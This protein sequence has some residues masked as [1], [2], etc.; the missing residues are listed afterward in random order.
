MLTFQ[1]V[2][3]LYSSSSSREI[4]NPHMH[5]QHNKDMRMRFYWLQQ[6][7]GC[8]FLY[9]LSVG[10]QFPTSMPVSHVECDTGM[11]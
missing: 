3:A 7:Q 4:L 6:T 1:Q 2:E 5:T 9:R 8:L 10:E 11:H